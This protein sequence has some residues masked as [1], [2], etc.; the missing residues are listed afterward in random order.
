MGERG[1]AAEFSVEGEQDVEALVGL[2]NEIKVTTHQEL[3]MKAAIAKHVEGCYIGL[4]FSD[5]FKL[6]D[7]PDWVITNMLSNA[8]NKIL[9]L[10]GNKGFIIL[11]RVGDNRVVKAMITGDNK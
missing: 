4:F 10:G 2:A 3:A 7:V 11:R 8:E 6:D 5:D 9:L 1:F